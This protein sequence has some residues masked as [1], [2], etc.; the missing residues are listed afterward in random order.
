MRKFIIDLGRTLFTI[1]VQSIIL[2]SISFGLDKLI[3]KDFLAGY[4]LWDVYLIF[5]CLLVANE[6]FYHFKKIITNL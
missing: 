6:T 2:T 4:S 5:I 1:N 3:K